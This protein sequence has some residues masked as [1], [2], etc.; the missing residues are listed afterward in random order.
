MFINFPIQANLK[1]IRQRGQQLIDKNFVRHDRK[2]Y[3]YYFCV[4]EEILVKTYDPT[5]MEESLH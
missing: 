1:T 2:K 3:D 4:G 5:K